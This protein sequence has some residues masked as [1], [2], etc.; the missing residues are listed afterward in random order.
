MIP[1]PPLVIDFA[2]KYAVRIG[3]VILTL[4]LLAAGYYKLIDTGRKLERAEWIKR[5]QVITERSENLLRQKQQEFDLAQKKNQEDYLNAIKIYV[6][7]GEDSVAKLRADTPRVRV[8][9]KHPS[10]DS[11]TLPREAN[12]PSRSNREGE[13]V[14]TFSELD[15]RVAE[16][17]KQWSVRNDLGRQ[18]C[19]QI[20]DFVT[21]NGMVK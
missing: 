11:S 12:N 21:S 13:I 3:L 1:I 9:T 14:G 7:H 5:E 2:S 10:C 17:L 4:I 8:V 15:D 6:K 16:N 19:Q 20:V 18:D